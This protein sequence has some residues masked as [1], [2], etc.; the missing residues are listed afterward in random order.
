MLKSLK[1]SHENHA[2]MRDISRDVSHDVMYDD[3]KVDIPETNHTVIAH[4]TYYAK[5]M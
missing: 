4:T 3:V 1:A 2:I 5:S